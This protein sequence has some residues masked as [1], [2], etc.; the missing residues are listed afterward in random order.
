MIDI[1][2]D[3]QPGHVAV[4]M[5]YSIALNGNKCVSARLFL[6]TFFLVAEFNFGMDE[7]SEIQHPE[8]SYLS[9]MQTVSVVNLL[10]L[11]RSDESFQA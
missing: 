10:G 8:L 11:V 1:S 6:R 4:A 9:F 3:F 2:D 7:E 5:G